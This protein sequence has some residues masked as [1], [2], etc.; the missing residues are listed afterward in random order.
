[1]RFV[2]AL[3]SV[4]A[5][6]AAGGSALAQW[7][8]PFSP[9]QRMIYSNGPVF[10]GPGSISTTMADVQENAT[11]A[12]SIG[13]HA[14]IGTPSNGS[15]TTA[16]WGE[17]NNPKGRALQGFNFA[18]TASGDVNNP[19]AGIWAETASPDGQGLRARA[20]S[21]TGA[22][23]AA[24]YDNASNAGTAL[25]ATS[26]AASGSTYGVW[27][28]VASSTGYAAYFTGGQN[29]FQGNVGIGTGSPAYP[30]TIN[31]DNSNTTLAATNA[32]TGAGNATGGPSAVTG[33]ISSNSPGVWAA[34]VWGIS[35]GTNAN[36]LGVAAYQAGSGIA[37]YGRVANSN[38]WAGYFV[39]NV[40]VTGTLS[41]AGGSFKIDHPLDP[42]NKYLYHSFVESPDMMNIYNGN[43]TTDLRGYATIQLPEY[44]EALN[45][46]FRYQLTVI[47][48]SDSNWTLV[49][50]VRE[51]S[52]N[53]FAIRTSA[54]NQKVSWQVTGVRKD[55]WAEKNRI[56]NAVDK[57]P[58]NKGRY[59]H[60]AAFGKPDSS[61]IRVLYDPKSP[62]TQLDPLMPRP[63]NLQAV[64]PSTPKAEP[65]TPAIAGGR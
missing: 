63:A 30:L 34:G 14:F 38:G 21:V 60:P 22:S 29:Y 25:Y 57:E 15:R 56:P 52:N 58:Y 47:D 31:G 39:G 16:L 24:Y 61:G 64:K 59:L 46:D 9:D 35:Y 37:V 32:T 13:L 26:T 45:R 43:V 28:N 51:V 23:Y 2:H 7:T 33:L 48:D 4:A 5:L 50:V 11:G 40:G 8:G 17:T 12:R 65:L 55:A 19:A 1:M 27:G 54:P 42:E 10:I 20:T 53:E 36:S 44:F 49:K 3:A 62:E 41:K 6:V 18:N